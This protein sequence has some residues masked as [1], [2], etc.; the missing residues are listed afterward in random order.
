MHLS[1]QHPHVKTMVFT[2]LSSMSGVTG[3]MG[4]FFCEFTLNGD[5]SPPRLSCHLMPTSLL[6]FWV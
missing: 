6:T 1:N 2:P 5:Y 3:S 4:P